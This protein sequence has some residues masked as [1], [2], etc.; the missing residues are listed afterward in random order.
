MSGKVDKV[1]YN[2]L[3]KESYTRSVYSSTKKYVLRRHAEESRITEN[4]NQMFKIIIK[5][6]IISN[7]SLVYRCQVA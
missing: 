6:Q 5:V 1:S 2:S 3:V 4:T 7:W